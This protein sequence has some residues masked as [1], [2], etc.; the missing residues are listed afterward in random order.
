[1]VFVPAQPIRDILEEHADELGWLLEHR[2]RAVHSPDHRPRDVRL[3]D[4]RIVAHA[5][6]LVVAG[7]DA[8]PM[9]VDIVEHAGDPA[10]VAG[11]AF[12]LVMSEDARVD[13]QPLGVRMAA[14]SVAMACAVGDALL[15]AR[16]KNARAALAAIAENGPPRATAG[17]A[18]AL[19][20]A[21]DSKRVPRLQTLVEDA[22]P[23][24]RNAGW[25]ELAML[26]WGGQRANGQLLSRVAWQARLLAD[27]EGDDP[28]VRPAALLAAVTTR[29]AFLLPLVLEKATGDS[30][31]DL[32]VAEI[33][34]ALATPG[35]LVHFMRMLARSKLGLGRFDVAA[36]YGSPLLV[37]AL[38]D[39]MAWPEPGD[40]LAA[41]AAFTR[42]TGIDA[43][44]E[45]TL[46]VP[47]DWR[48]EP[49]DVDEDALEKVPRPDPKE[50]RARWEAARDRF[51]D[52]TRL[53]RGVPMPQTGASPAQHAAMDMR[54][55]WHDRLRASY[56]GTAAKPA[57][58]DGLWF[59][60][61][62]LD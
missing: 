26:T 7:R 15:L 30:R 6:A 33:G 36:S 48:D 22:D 9:L 62:P 19:T 52:A 24:A 1:M 14:A 18:L 17:A 61:Q 28:T 34:A 44:T 20:G 53:C 3:L 16:P 11:A 55:L 49:T 57:A 47:A 12:A 38:I 23:V 56:H 37:D 51:G 4:A 59:G 43:A 25:T 60:L 21:A 58:V 13:L 29:Q 46:R 41:S 45:G 50:T 54:A 42:I 2:A 8:E 32:P 10:S 27:C 40:A 35:D 31:A 39:A 5:D